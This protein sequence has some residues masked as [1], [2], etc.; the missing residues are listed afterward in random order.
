MKKR[1]NL[2]S[3]AP[4]ALFAL[5]AALC[6][7]AY[8]VILSDFLLL[9][10]MRNSTKIIK[11]VKS[12]FKKKKI[13]YTIVRWEI[14]PDVWC[15]SIETMLNDISIQFDVKLKDVDDIVDIYGKVPSKTPILRDTNYNIFEVRTGTCKR[16]FMKGGSGKSVLKIEDA[17]EYILSNNFNHLR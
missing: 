11:A 6:K 15:V 8:S 14:I 12:F 1:C 5:C 13:K 16:A 4:L 7:W 2:I 3:Y 9:F 17:L 10:I